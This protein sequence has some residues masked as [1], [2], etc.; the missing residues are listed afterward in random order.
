MHDFPNENGDKKVRRN[1]LRRPAFTLVELLVVIAIIGIL[2]GLLLPAVQSAREAARRM[3]CSN[4]LKQIGLAMHNY[5]SAYKRLPPG[6]LGW[7]NDDEP[8]LKDDDGYGFLCFLLPFLEQTNLYNQVNPNGPWE[9]AHGINGT[10]MRGMAAAIASGSATPYMQARWQAATTPVPTYLCPS[11]PMPANAPIA[12]SHPGSPVGQL[13]LSPVFHA[14]QEEGLATSSYKGM[15]G[16]PFGD[17]SMF[18]KRAE[19]DARKF[20][21]VTDG[22]SNTIAVAESTYLRPDGCATKPCTNADAPVRAGDWPVWI[23]MAATDESMRITARTASPINGFTSANRMYYAIDDDCA[24]SFHVGGA[25]FAF[26]DGSVHFISQNISMATYA[27]L[28]G[29]NDGEVVGQW[30]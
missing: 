23:G 7:I 6:G 27:R 29:M 21:D 11:S 3:S 24:F 26:G 12:Y 9:Q 5:E 17:G 13:P 20:G 28:G 4:N 10:P 15:G 16:T 8:P 30:E 22:L 18:V 25:Q 2:V 19:G 1:S 14:G